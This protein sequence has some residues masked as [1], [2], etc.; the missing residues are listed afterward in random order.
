MFDLNPQIPKSVRKALSDIE[1]R[2]IMLRANGSSIRDIAKTLKKSNN[3]ICDW[4]KKF[5]KEILSARNNVFCELQQKIIELK[6]SR[7]NF[8]KEELDR[9]TKIIKKEN[10]K[11]TSYSS[12]YDKYFDRYTKLAN[13]MSTYELEMLDV[14]INFK[15]NIEPEFD[16]KNEINQDFSA[17]S[18]N[19]RKYSSDSNAENSSKIQ[20]CKNKDNKIA[21]N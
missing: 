18:K 10:I 4:N 8:I 15:D 21:T 13:L 6:L 11:V 19:S 16:V 1:K 2:F 20:N 14:G 3:T 9:L 12:D 7:L 17:N 5:A